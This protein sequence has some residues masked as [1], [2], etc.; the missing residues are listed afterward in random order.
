MLPLKHTASKHMAYY[1]QHW[2]DAPRAH[3]KLPL[4]VGPKTPKIRKKIKRMSIA[5]LFA[6]HA[7]T[8]N[9]F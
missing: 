3:R 2:L 1:A 7:N 5:K 8:K 9:R 4:K 6:L